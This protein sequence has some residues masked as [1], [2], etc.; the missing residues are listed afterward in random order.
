MAHK[1]K[2]RKPMYTYVNL[3]F[4]CIESTQL[5]RSSVLVVNGGGGEN[6]GARDWI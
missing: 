6:G 4:V 5:K 2:E 1:V 3:F